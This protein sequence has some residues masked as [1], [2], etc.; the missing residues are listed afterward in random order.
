MANFYPSLAVSVAVNVFS[1]FLNVNFTYRLGF[2]IVPLLLNFF[3][4]RARIEPQ[5]RSI[6]FLDWVTQDRT[7]KS[8]VELDTAG[9]RALLF[10]NSEV[11]RG[12]TDRSGVLDLAASFEE[13][14]KLN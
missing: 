7:A 6:Q 12:L 9:I 1:H 13:L 8:K 10:S 14:L 5:F 4:N 11:F 2:T 3:Y